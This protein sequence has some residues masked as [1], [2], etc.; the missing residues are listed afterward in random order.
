MVSQRDNK[1]QV[2]HKRIPVTREQD[3]TWSTKYKPVQRTL[4]KPKE[5]LRFTEGNKQGYEKQ[6]SKGYTKI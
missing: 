1:S 4:E 2:K 6:K 5:P 3:T